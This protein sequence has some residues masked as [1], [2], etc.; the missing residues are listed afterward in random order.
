ME[1]ILDKSGW[2]YLVLSLSSV[3]ICCKLV[4]VYYVFVSDVQN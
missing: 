4:Q 3:C 1:C 2:I